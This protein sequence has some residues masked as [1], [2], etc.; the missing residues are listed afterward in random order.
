MAD[1]KFILGGSSAVGGDQS[2][3][4]SAE[5][6]MGLFQRRMALPMEAPKKKGAAAK[7][8]PRELMG[9]MPSGGSA[10]AVVEE[11]APIQPASRVV[12]AGLKAKRGA[13][14][15]LRWC[16]HGELGPRQSAGDDA[17]LFQR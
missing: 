2:I 8:V 17:D 3:G 7:K 15:G 10:S 11:L 5:S 4:A 6:R 13:E 12:L 16:V 14:R 1:V 9:L